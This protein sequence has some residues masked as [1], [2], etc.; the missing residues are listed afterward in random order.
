[1]TYYKSQPWGFTS[2]LLFGFYAHVKG[3][4]AITMCEEEL[5]VAR[6]AERNENIETGGNASL[7]SEMIANFMKGKI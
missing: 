7:T 3:S 5:R 2:T 4:D 1:M 6:W